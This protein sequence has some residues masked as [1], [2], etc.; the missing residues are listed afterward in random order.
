MF[1]V[2]FS[3][4]VQRDATSAGPGRKDVDGRESSKGARAGATSVH[5]VEQTARD[6]RVVFR[7]LKPKRWVGPDGIP[8][9]LVRDCR[10]GLDQ[11]LL[12]VF[13]LCL[14]KGHYPDIWEVTRVIP[15][16]KEVSGSDVTG[17]RPVAVL[18]AFAKVFELALYKC[19]YTQASSQL[20]VFSLVGVR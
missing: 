10:A 2:I 13:N 8:P 7:R 3:V 20:T 17:Y 4:S 14:Q 15:V 9:Y 5:V 11:P 1:C 6:M 19:I 12:H 18:S 16:P